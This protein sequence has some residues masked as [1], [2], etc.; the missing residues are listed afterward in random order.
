MAASS[1]SSN[2]SADGA[3]KKKRRRKKGVRPEGRPEVRYVSLA[4]E[5]RR[6]YLN[7]ALSV[8]GSRALPDARDGLKPVQRRILYVMGRE[9]NLAPGTKTVKC[10]RIVGDTIGKYH[11][12]GDTAAYDTLVR[13]A[14][15][16][17]MRVPLVEGQGNF[18][19][20]LGLPAAA[21]RYTEARLTAPA[22]SLMAELG[23]N[24]VPTR[25]T[26]DA[27][28]TEPVVFP[29][30]FPH[31]L[32]NGATGIAVGMATNIP[33]HNLREVVNS[34]CHLI[35]DP[36][37]T[38][39]ALMQKGV[40][41]PDFPLGGRIVSD[42]T[43]IRTAYEEGRGSIKVRAM[44]DFDPE[45]DQQKGRRKAQPARLV[46]DSLPHGVTSGAVIGELKALAESRKLPQMLEADD[47][48]DRAH[49]LR[50]VVTVRGKEDA[51][52]VMAYLYKHTA[53]E[54]NF[55]VNLT[56]LV[57][58]DTF[59]ASEDYN[60][61]A[62]QGLGVKEAGDDDPAETALIDGGADVPLV[63]RRLD[64]KQL[65]RVFL[66]F[67]LQT[68]TRRLKHD[69]RAL[70]RRIH[71]LEGYE[72]LF[73]GIDRALRLI[74]E[75]N[76]K[77]DAREKLMDAFP[78]DERQTNS[79]LEMMLYKISRLEID[80]ILGELA[81]KRAEADRLVKLLSDK[82]ALWAL[83]RTELKEIGDRFG[84]RRR[85][86]LGG[87]EE[88]EEFDPTAYIVR[89]DTNVV[90]TRDGWIKRL[91][92]INAVDALRTREG[93]ETLCVLGAST[94]DAIVFFA[95]D[96]T[97]YTLPVEQIPASTGYGE[98][99]GKHV[100]LDDGVKI[101]A[102]ISTDQ[103]FT[104][105]DFEVEGTPSL[106]PHLF[107]ATEQGQVSRVGLSSFRD[108]STRGGRKFLRLT[109]DDRVI[110][111]ERV[112]GAESVFLA[113]KKA[114][115]LHFKVD[116]VPV[117]AGPG[118]GVK[119]IDLEKSDAVLGAQLCR[120]PSDVLHVLNVNEK[121]L[122]FG[123]M[124]YTPTGRGGKGVKTSQRT[125]FKQVLHEGPDLVDWAA[126]K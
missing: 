77:A 73:S 21:A 67:R 86:T 87:S 98:P 70:R 125:G 72:I 39:A 25:P 50:I 116:S 57:P 66:D 47:E 46:I 95:E 12:H 81:E 13:L 71:L 19:S 82:S 31:L 119:G 61:E 1:P 101:V 109:G 15:D 55:A 100:K 68:V 59:A 27:E 102:A 97:A 105:L 62:L 103:R 74:R 83:I 4:E 2:G 76:G 52:A 92:T 63:P 9:L 90:L 85:T 60:A 54:Q 65:L 36:D 79:I 114:R 30:A 22:M 53:L 106:A 111:V 126:A 8:I 89:E 75:S 38:V 112:D 24:T 42:R 10:A 17:A 121:E 80:T 123:Q 58:D 115:V 23:K 44:W 26:Y 117:L 99:L 6:R 7:Y 14:Q 104:P 69:L 34:A 48:T 16:H 94:L 18:G 49:G 110:H 28:R 5:T 33:P 41:G 56:A 88:V 78:L 35:D 120:R 64:L 3:P 20:V 29:A 107:V 32:V 11:P 122:P 118:K 51:E 37:A 124:K 96:G 91:G 108:V 45:D 113:T 93:D 40:K 84:D 43:D